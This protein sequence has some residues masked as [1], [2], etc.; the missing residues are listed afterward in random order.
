MRRH[1]DFD[2][3]L[4]RVSGHDPTNTATNDRAFFTQQEPYTTSVSGSGI[5]F[6]QQG[7]VVTVASV[8]APFLTPSTRQTIRSCN[9]MHS[10][11]SSPL[12]EPDT[13]VLISTEGQGQGPQWKKARLSHLINVAPSEKHSHKLT[14]HN[15][16]QHR[17]N[18]GV[19]FSTLAV[20]HLTEADQDDRREE[21]SGS[22]HIARPTGTTTVSPSSSSSSSASSLGVSEKG[23]F[24]DIVSS[25]FGLVSPAVFRNTLSTGVISN[26]IYATSTASFSRP[27]SS[28][29]NVTTKKP[30]LLLT[31]TQIFPGSE[32]GA[33]VLHDRS[34][35]ILVGIVASPL[36]RADG[37]VV[38]LAAIIPTHLFLQRLGFGGILPLAPSPSSSTSSTARPPPPPP[39]SPPPH[40]V[41]P[42][43][44]KRSIARGNRSLVCVRAG[45]AWGSGILMSRQ[46]HIITCAHLIKPVLAT[47]NVSNTTTTHNNPPLRTRQRV[48]V[49]IDAEINHAR[50]QATPKWHQATVLFCS[51]GTLDMACIQ[52]DTRTIP[53]E[54]LPMEI[55]SSCPNQ[56]SSAVAIGHALFDPQSNLSA[57]VSVGSVAKVTPFRAQPMI[58]QTSASV[59]R[60]DSG[61]M[62]VS[63]TSGK[64][65]GMITSN[66]RQA[67]SGI[68][69]KLNF[70]ISSSLL[71]PVVLP[72]PSNANT[73][74]TPM[75]NRHTSNVFHNVLELNRWFKHFELLSRE[76]SLSS[77]WDLENT[78]EA[79]IHAEMHDAGQ[80]LVRSKL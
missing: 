62:I 30:V 65:L 28:I 61:G 56:G 42:R 52:L 78:E 24:V 13:H 20:L 9:R 37:S 76:P 59:Y 80:P 2:G 71:H 29:R 40:P 74:T 14:G 21:R 4:V 77:L 27:S 44:L 22:Q 31:D 11:W 33:V 39:L 57:T 46:G 25:P 34:N 45:A 41:S 63:G 48:L 5:H 17:S 54:A 32:G 36:T 1:V 49:R 64:L 10:T 58:V 60:G 67:E 51:T 7:I 66:A 55:E 6:F 70:S 68:I 75:H 43:V 3:A 8:L 69:P 18:N 73:C 19:P 79:L 38:E 26:I 53:T 35:P 23:D 50:P 15:N 16:H 72:M 12:L 47:N